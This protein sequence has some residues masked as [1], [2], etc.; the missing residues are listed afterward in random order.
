MTFGS[1]CACALGTAIPLLV[2]FWGNVTDIYGNLDKMVDETKH[3]MFNALGIAAGALLTGWGMF[4]C[5]VVAAERQGIACRKYYLRSLLRQEI[6]WFDTINQL[7]LSSKFVNDT[8]AF[9]G[10]ISEKVCTIIM[11]ISTLITSLII[12]FIKGWLMALVTLACLPA[13][14]LGSYLYAFAISKKDSEL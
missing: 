6:G 8:S 14:I 12:A 5:W 7:E 9:Q 4:G 3:A 1:L 11:T 10:A 2:I 13:I